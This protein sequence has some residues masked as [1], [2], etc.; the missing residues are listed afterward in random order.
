MDPETFDVQDLGLAR[1]QTIYNTGQHAITEFLQIDTPTI[2][3]ASHIQPESPPIGA[4]RQL[5]QAADGSSSSRGQASQQQPA[6]Q[7]APGTQ[8]AK[9]ATQQ[10]KQQPAQPTQK[11]APQPAA[12]RSVPEVVAPPPAQPGKILTEESE[13][14]LL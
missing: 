4:R 14:V 12:P 1:A 9:Q 7:A 3:R 2:Q 11:P 6:R 5:S 8:Q 10:P 13:E